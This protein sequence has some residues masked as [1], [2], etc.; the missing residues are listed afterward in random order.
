[1]TRSTVIAG[2]CWALLLTSASLAQASSQGSVRGPLGV[3]AKVNIEDAI[4][5][6]PSPSPTPAELHAYLRQLYAK[7]L[8][9]PAIAGLTVGA[10]WSAIQLSADGYDW[11]FV[12]DAFAEAALAHKSVQL[13]ITP[14]FDSPSWLLAEIPSCDG[15][16]GGTAAAD[17]G[18]V[19]FVKFPESQR[20]DGNV[21]PLPWNDTYEQAWWNFLIHLNARYKANPAFVAIALAGP[22]GASTEMIL[23][24]SANDPAPQPS[25][26]SVD[27]TWAALIEHSFPSTPSYQGSD[28]VF[29]DQWKRTIDAYETI[30]AGVT[31]FLSPDAGNDLPELGTEV[32]P[33]PDNKLYVRDCKSATKNPISCEAK[34]EVLSYFVSVAGPNG[35]ATQVGGMTASSLLTTGDIGIAGVKLLTSLS[36]PPSPSFLGG[37]EFDHP[38]SGNNIQQEGCPGY[39]GTVCKNLTVELA[40]YNA[41]TVFFYGTPAAHS[42]GGKPGPAPMRYLDVPY[43][44]VQYAQ[45]HPCPTTPVASI[46]KASL[47]DLL[48]RASHDLLQMAG[49]R[50]PLPP[51]TCR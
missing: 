5:A 20:A 36:P 43:L 1:M 27:D 44:D 39:P 51:P 2:V 11:S 9:D 15:M 4:S 13:I 19:T 12:D 48:N 28:Q 10:H 50:V 33:H 32:K 31:L 46:G 23:P 25:K 7:L 35:K 37:A 41:L 42:Y 16:F 18:T 17:C 47:Q 49:R 3:Y 14:G 34:T 22:I 45:A 26:L 6:F 30:F 29:I 24:T 38:V 21:L 40:A 8:A